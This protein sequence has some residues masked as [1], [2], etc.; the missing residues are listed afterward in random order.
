MYNTNA[1]PYS[2]PY[3]NMQNNQ[4]Y[5][6][7]QNNPY[8]QQPNY[9]DPKMINQLNQM[10]LNN[11]K[12]R[13]HDEENDLQP[14]GVFN[15]SDK[16]VR[17]GFIRKVYLILSAQMIMTTLFVLI[18]FLVSG[19]RVFQRTHTWIPIAASVITIIIVYALACF[20]SVA[21]SVPI[22]YILL[23]I[24]TLA[25]SYVVS[26]I[27]SRY[28]PNTVLIA[29]SLTAII[30]IS[31]TLYA[32][33]T[34]TDFTTCG[35]VLLV[36]SVGLFFGS[37]IGIFLKSNVYNMII[38]VVSAIIFGIYLVFDTQL[39]IG[40]NS[41]AYSVDDYIFAA[42]NLYVD[43]IIIFLKLL[44]IIGSIQNN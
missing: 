36:C 37:I 25:E 19:F 35:G 7:N 21:R 20:R 17:L 42:M 1:D 34:K 30:V 38:A 22:N 10:A 40:T 23:A 2:N 28:D 33:F 31:L 3:S 15:A 16:K 12:L 11:A 29:A 6:M 8:N 18:A 5:N 4:G 14:Y 41:N 9:T 24:F 39:V 27:A 44:Q 43:I 26:F 32:I 13:H